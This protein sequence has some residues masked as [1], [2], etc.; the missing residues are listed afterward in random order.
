M[1][2]PLE[3]FGWLQR[4]GPGPIPRAWQVDPRVHAVF[5][6]RAKEESR[7]RARVRELLQLSAGTAGETIG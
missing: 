2:E 7:R 1:I 3:I 5:A 6:A 4:E